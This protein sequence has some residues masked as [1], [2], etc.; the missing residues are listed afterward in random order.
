MKK[1]AISPDPQYFNRYISL[2][3]DIDLSEALQQSLYALQTL[4][5]N[6]LE[7]KAE[8]AYAPEKWTVKDVLQHI[9]DTERVF[10][11]RALM[12]ARGDQQH[13]PGMDQEAYAAN[14][15]TKHRTVKDL[16]QELI[17]VRTVTIALFNSFSSDEILLRT[18]TS[19][20]Y[21]VSVLAI[22]FMIAGH[23]AH[24]LNILREKYFEG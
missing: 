5:I 16:M 2:I 17:A 12:F 1:D 4:D 3:P 21:E 7:T 10:T 6:E 22:G 8:Y 19:W 20:K 13:A 11:Y 15:S 9:T 18:G 23:Q 14:T 24:H